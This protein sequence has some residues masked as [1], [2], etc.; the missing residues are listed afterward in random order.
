MF[1]S[2][3]L[4]DILIKLVHGFMYNHNSWGGGTLWDIM[5]SLGL[6]TLMWKI[7]WQHNGNSNA[8]EDEDEDEYEEEDDDDYDGG[9]DEKD[10]NL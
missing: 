6:I 5:L 10:D 7:H 4:K 2:L 8:A 1:N 9:G 3:D